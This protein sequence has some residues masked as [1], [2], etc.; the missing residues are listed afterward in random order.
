MEK[1][2]GLKTHGQQEMTVAI[3]LLSTMA[4]ALITGWLA[5]SISRRRTKI[6]AG[7]VYIT[8]A[9]GGALAPT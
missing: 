7:L 3:L 2:L 4:G 8:G 9:I 6:I 5:D 1:D